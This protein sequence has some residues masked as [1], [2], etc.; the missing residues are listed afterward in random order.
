MSTHQTPACG[1]ATAFPRKACEGEPCQCGDCHQHFPGGS[2]W[3]FPHGNI[4]DDCK[5]E[6]TDKG[7]QAEAF[8]TSPRQAAAPSITHTAAL[9]TIPSSEPQGSNRA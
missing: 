7:L 9:P 4:C 3:C 8:G 6:R 5:D 1:V 2:L